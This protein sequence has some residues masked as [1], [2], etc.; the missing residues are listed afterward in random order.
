MSRLLAKNRVFCVATSLW[1]DGMSAGPPTFY[2]FEPSA[3]SLRTCSSAYRRTLNPSSPIGGEFPK[4]KMRH[5]YSTP[6]SP[7][8]TR[9]PPLSETRTI[10]PN[11]KLKPNF[12]VRT[13]KTYLEASKIPAATTQS[14]P[15]RNPAQQSLNGPH[16]APSTRPQHLWK[17]KPHEI[18]SAASIQGAPGQVAPYRRRS[19]EGRGQC[20]VEG[21]QGLYVP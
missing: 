16:A 17:S 14:R 13:P 20:S 8:P 18:P 10:G 6:K 9:V 11:P 15:I 21:S 2:K 4:T 1:V 3:N 7:Q 12:K 19:G 5:T